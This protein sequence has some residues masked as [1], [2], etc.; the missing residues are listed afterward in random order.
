MR[1]QE[2]RH[3]YLEMKVN[4]GPWQETQTWVN[5]MEKDV[6]DVTGSPGEESG[7]NITYFGSARS[8]LSSKTAWSKSCFKVIDFT[9]ETDF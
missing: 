9:S 3:T 5:D 8:H 7:T 2:P 4:L 6:E 1:F